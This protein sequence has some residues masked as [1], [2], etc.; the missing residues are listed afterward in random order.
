MA[1]I[2][3]NGDHLCKKYEEYAAQMRDQGKEPDHPAIWISAAAKVELVKVRDL[4]LAATK[5][6]RDRGAA[7]KR[8]R[9]GAGSQ[10]T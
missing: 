9:L 1:Q 8:R 5:L 2:L 10:A 6:V 3:D 4:M 7:L